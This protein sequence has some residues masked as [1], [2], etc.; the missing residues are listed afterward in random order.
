M[1]RRLATPLFLTL[2]LALTV[3]AVAPPE[4]DAADGDTSP[5][6][7]VASFLEVPILRSPVLSPDAR[8]VAYIWTRRDLDSVG[9]AVLVFADFAR[10]CFNGV[11]DFDP[12]HVLPHRKKPRMNANITAA[13]IKQTVSAAWCMA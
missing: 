6:F 1:L 11:G 2:A 13:M 5:A 7:T 3:T 12:D 4:G 9:V 10:E 8:Q